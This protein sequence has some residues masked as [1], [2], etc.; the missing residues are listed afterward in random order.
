MSSRLGDDGGFAQGAFVAESVSLG[1]CTCAQWTRVIDGFYTFMIRRRWKDCD[2]SCSC[3]EVDA[4]ADKACMRWTS[5]MMR[6]RR[7]RVHLLAL[8]L[9]TTAVGC[10]VAG[11]SSHCGDHRAHSTRSGNQSEIVWSSHPRAFARWSACVW[12]GDVERSWLR[13]W[14]G[15]VVASSLCSPKWRTSKTPDPEKWKIEM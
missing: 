15:E 4:G 8:P 10:L 14:C 1:G 6:V 9:S 12:C 3:P 13:R 2:P 5:L 11:I 7:V